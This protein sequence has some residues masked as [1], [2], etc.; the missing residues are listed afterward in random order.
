AITRGVF[1]SSVNLLYLMNDKNNGRLGAF[2][3]MSVRDEQ[4]FNSSI[5]RWLN[6][7]DG[8][9]AEV[10]K[11][12]FQPKMPTETE[13]LEVVL[14]DLGILIEDLP[15]WPSIATRAKEVGEVWDFYYDVKYRGLSSWQHGDVSRIFVSPGYA[16]I[17]PSQ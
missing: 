13:I 6:H 3:R 14:R 4:K 17:D 12:Q 15:P 11:L 7:P 9:I 1:E 8:D 16:R 2:W 10:A 5:K